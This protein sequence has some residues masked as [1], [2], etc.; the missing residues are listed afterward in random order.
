MAHKFVEEPKG[1]LAAWMNTYADMV[2]LLLCFFVLLFS[3][4]S[5]DVHKYKAAL[6]SFEV[7]V[8]VMPGG[9]ALSGG[10]MLT[11]G[12]NQLNEVEVILE[13]K[14]P[15]TDPDQTEGEDDGKGTDTQNK[16]DTGS[17]DNTGTVKEDS[18]T[19]GMA[20]EILEYL[21]NEG[22]DNKVIV[23][24]N[25]GYVKL[26]L[27]GETL[28]DSGSAT[29]KSEAIEIIRNLSQMIRDKKY[30]N[31]VL[32]I[33]GHT[34]NVPISSFQYP[35]NWYLSSARA[36]A[37]GSVFI[38]E[39]GFDPD[40]VACT[41]YGEYRPVADNSTADGRALN[42]RVEIKI[43]IEK[44]ENEALSEDMVLSQEE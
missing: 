15:T 3:M 18:L 14:N 39:Y 44:D 38:N 42:R 27:E 7:K 8:D 29:I 20:K 35:N 6:G 19:A 34:D 2:T 23:S 16:E 28:F 5:V 43:V 24:Y 31:Y 36:I 37:V 32:Q 33:E 17:N 13:R 1:G 25:D 40:K 26:S 12:I 30:D 10:E 41:G 21:N 9:I 22:L 4:S 11:N